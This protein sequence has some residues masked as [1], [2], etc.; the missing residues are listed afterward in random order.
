MLEAAVGDFLL[1]YA[2][3]YEHVSRDSTKAMVIVETRP[4]FWLPYVIANASH[5][6]GYEL[7]VFGSR[8]V[9]DLVA[10][11]ISGRYKTVLLADQRLTTQQ[12]SQLLFSKPFWELIEQENILVFQCDCVLLRSVAEEAFGFDFI[13]PMCGEASEQRFIVN[14][15][16]SLRTKSGMLRALKHVTQEDELRNPEDVVF[17]RIMRDHPDEFK[18][19]TLTDCYKFAI[20][21]LGDVR[22]AIGIH[23]TDKYY[24]DT[25]QVLREFM[26]SSTI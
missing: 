9:L 26:D 20:E 18:L 22:S 10:S 15:G 12:Y 13:G 25:A 6:L 23:G 1:K 8:P 16:L 19:P 17:T 14:G 3:P 21:S 7:Y 5:V 24:T 4:A 2:L 11:S